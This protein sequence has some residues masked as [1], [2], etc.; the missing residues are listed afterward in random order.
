MARRSGDARTLGNV[1]F[2]YIYAYASR[3]GLAEVRVLTDE[4]LE[5]VASLD[6]PALRFRTA[7][8]Q[9]IW[10]VV[11]GKLADA[12][13]EVAHIRTIATELG[14]PVVRWFA[15]YL[16]AAFQAITGDLEGSEPGSR[17]A[18]ARFPTPSARWLNR[19]RAVCA[20]WAPSC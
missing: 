5:I 17:R 20:S 16:D 10:L 2:D 13:A 15:T 12:G 7:A 4:L 6:D 9:A 3:H 1:L 11:E 14:Q 18:T 8:Q 19:L